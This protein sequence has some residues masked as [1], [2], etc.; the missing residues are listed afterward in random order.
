MTSRKW[1]CVINN[2]TPETDL[3]FLD[4]LECKYKIYAKETG[5]QGTPHL[6]CFIIFKNA[7]R[8]ASLKKLNPRAHW[9]PCKGQDEANIN[10]CKKGGLY[11]ESDT[12]TQGFRTDL[13]AI[14]ASIKTI[15]L[16][17]TREDM[18]EAY[19]RYKSGMEA[20]A[21]HYVKKRDFKPTV[22]WLYGTSGTGKTRQ[23]VEAEKDLWISGR[24]LKFWD[25]YENQQAVL[26]DDFRK[27]FC[28]FH[29][30][31]RI[32]DR[33]PYRVNVKGGS[34]ELNSLRIYI[35]SCHHPS[36][37]YE[38]REDLKQL[39]RRID[40]IKHVIGDP[41]ATTVP[42]AQ[43]VEGNTKLLPFEEDDYD[44]GDLSEE[45]DGC[46]LDMK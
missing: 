33:Y 3:A 21:I 28:T 17:K 39:Q 13:A 6:Q 29:E 42:V 9:E 4:A 34:R 24:D 18:P 40:T 45:T 43:V 32:L 15:G 41:V 46:D 16:N 22:T 20:L 19:L 30:L 36:Q 25:G 26:I 27:D 14:A 1:I 7:C 2:W 10:Y 31:L 37:V 5:E 23:V 12:R 38:T 44:S 11:I 8:L 35:T